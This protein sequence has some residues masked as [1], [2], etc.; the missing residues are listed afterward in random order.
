MRPLLSRLH[1]ALLR[2]E[3]GLLV[4]ALAAMIL[5]ACTQ[6]L[7][8]N[9]WDSGISWGDPTLRVLVLWVTLLGAMAATREG[10]HIRID[11]LSRY[12]PERLRDW[13]RRLTDLFAASVTGLLAWHSGRF[14]V[15]EW[16]DGGVLFGQVPA[17]ACEAIMPLGFTVMALRFL[18]ATLLG[19]PAR[20]EPLP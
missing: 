13:S 7:L 4:T 19:R 20:A 1:S 6:I 16:E 8:R 18:T 9:L 11:L 12:L 15:F 3:D 10:N 17:W 2:I 5:L 14:V